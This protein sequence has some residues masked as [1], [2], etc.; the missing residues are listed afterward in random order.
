M[1]DFDGVN[2]QSKMRQK[3]RQLHKNRQIVAKLRTAVEK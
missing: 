1:Q 2:F 3:H